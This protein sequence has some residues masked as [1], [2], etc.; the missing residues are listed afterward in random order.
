MWATQEQFN[1]TRKYFAFSCID[2]VIISSNG[3]LLIKRENAPYEGLWHL[4]GGIIHK[5]QTM[6]QKVHEV[7]VREIGCDVEIV[8]LLGIFQNLHTYRHDIS[9]CFLAK[10]NDSLNRLE[11]GTNRRFFRKIPRNIIPFHK[12]LI[13]HAL[14]VWP[15]RN[16]A[17]ELPLI[18]NLL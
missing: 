12:Q 16:T 17:N 3:F 18:H 10:T 8:G 9:H 2:I 11:T 4:P 5:N 14:K 13:I 6:V 15:K 7:A 1:S